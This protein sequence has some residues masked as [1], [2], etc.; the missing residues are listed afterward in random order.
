MAFLTIRPVRAADWTGFDMA[1]QDPAA[2]LRGAWAGIDDGGFAADQVAGYQS[3]GLDSAVLFGT[4]FT[5]TGTGLAGGTVQGMAVRFAGERGASLYLLGFDLPTPQFFALTAG[6]GGAAFWH[7]VLAGRDALRGGAAHDRLAGHAGADAI[8]GARGNDALWGDGG[9]DTLIGDAWRDA[10]RGGAGRDILAGGAGRDTLAG[11]G[12][13]DAFVFSGTGAGEDRIADFAV[14]Q[15]RLW[16]DINAPA[17][18]DLGLG[19]LQGRAFALADAAADAATR[20]LYDPATGILRYDSD[21]SGDTPAVILARMD[22]GLDL[23]AAHIRLI[24]PRPWLVVPDAP[25]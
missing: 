22:A 25:F 4:G 17:F 8:D 7:S 12:G 13:R 1:A 21:G 18:F 9:D 14:A 11:G 2:W 3:P 20:I 23:T 5:D 15:D 10:L 16:L 6:D 19:G 24:D